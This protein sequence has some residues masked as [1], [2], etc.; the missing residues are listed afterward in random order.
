MDE[1]RPV[2]EATAASGARDTPAE[3]DGMVRKAFDDQ[4]SL[5]GKAEHCSLDPTRLQAIGCVAGSQIR[6][7]RPSQPDAI[8]TVS[9]TRPESTATTIRMGRDGRGRLDLDGPAD[10]F[11]VHVEARVP[12]SEFSDAEAR[13]RS[14]FVERL[15][16]DGCQNRLVVL[17]PH[18]GFIESR[19]DQQA[20]RLFTAPGDGQRQRLA[21]Q[22][23]RAGRR[24][25][26]LSHHVIRSA[27]FQFPLLAT[28]APRNFLHA[29][30]FHGFTAE[31][32]L[33]G[34][35]APPF[36]KEKVAQALEDLLAGEM[37]VRIADD[38][39]GFDGDN[40]CNIVNRLTA[41]GKGGVQIEQSRIARDKYWKEIADA[42]AGVYRRIC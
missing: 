21:V 13:R 4:K 36:V 16:D 9:E 38:S 25:Q 24:L 15:D 11:E 34:G 28:I 2:V 12:H 35:G 5:L 1:T 23:F 40:P 6:V 22:G 29:V 8:Y 10:A 33:I 20:E 41:G 26:A 30:A 17:A 42:V 37:P 27:R 19:T 14:E 32:V 7:G 39:D 31:G 3:F 18:G